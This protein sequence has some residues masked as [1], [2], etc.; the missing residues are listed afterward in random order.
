MNESDPPTPLPLEPALHEWLHAG[1][2]PADGGFSL[3]VMAALPPRV[4]AARRRRA[5]WLRWAQWVAISL[6]GCGAAALLT[7]GPGPP[8]AAHLLA[9]LV[10][11]ALLIFWTVPSRWN[12]P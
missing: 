11:V 5:R 4:G 9:G 1:D 8:D 7:D 10:L 12:R 3:R 6:A 2:E